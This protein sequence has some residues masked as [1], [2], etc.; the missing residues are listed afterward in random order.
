[1][2]IVINKQD[3]V[4]P[5]SRAEIIQYVQ[6][7]AHNVLGEKAVAP[8]SVS[9]RDGLAAK[10][11]G[12]AEKLRDSGLLDFENALVD[13]LANNRAQMF[14]SS[15]CDRTLAEMQALLDQQTDSLIPKLHGLRQQ[16][17]P[18]VPEASAALNET[19]FESRSGA[20]RCV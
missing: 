4:P 17:D 5:D 3:T 12:D 15:M 2:F 7:T 16:I 20:L 8:F 18:N 14:L 6:K 19:S 1:M 13:F 11:V 9:A 10:Q